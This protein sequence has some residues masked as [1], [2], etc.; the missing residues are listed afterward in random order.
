MLLKMNQ[1][2]ISKLV[3]SAQLVMEISMTEANFSGEQL[4]AEEA[5]MLAAFLPRCR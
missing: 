4:C 5:V 1:C 2:E 3:V